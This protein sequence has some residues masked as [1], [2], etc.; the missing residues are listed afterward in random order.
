MKI[1]ILETQTGF[2][3]AFDDELVDVICQVAYAVRDL[4]DQ[5]KRIADAQWHDLRKEKGR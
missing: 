5:Q 1:K 4:A 2:E 3:I